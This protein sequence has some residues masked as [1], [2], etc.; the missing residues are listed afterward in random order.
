MM[1]RR[2]GWL[3][4]GMLPLCAH[5][6]ETVVPVEPVATQDLAAALKSY[7]GRWVGHFTIHSTT[8]GYSETFPVE[9]QYWWEEGVL[10]GV[11]VTQR[12]V[13][14]S[15]AR[16]K[17]VMKNGKYF[18][19]MKTGETIENYWGVLHD[20]G[21][22]WFSSNLKRTQDY[23]MKESIVE[24]DGERVLK[25]EGFNTYLTGDGLAY[26]VYRGELKFVE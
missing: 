15:S 18:S 11:A 19:E 8:S 14:M 24:V 25:T 6:E 22:I 20:D 1:W 4:L 23:Q 9:Q 12:D 10:H 21:L 2:F 26:L 16:S 5:A 7:A 17:S 13:G 3:I